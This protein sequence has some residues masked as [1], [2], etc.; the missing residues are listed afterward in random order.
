RH[1]LC[2]DTTVHQA[3]YITTVTLNGGM[4]GSHQ[5]C[6]ISL[7]HQRSDRDQRTGPPGATVGEYG[8]SLG[9]DCVTQTETDVG[10]A[11]AGG[12]GAENELI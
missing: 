3:A 8:L 7:Y 4:L 1:N 10:F 9:G 12:G 5:P 6:P 11:L 2:R